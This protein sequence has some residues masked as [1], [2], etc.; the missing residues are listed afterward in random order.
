MKLWR[1]LLVLTI[2]IILCTGVGCTRESR[3]APV[4]SL[5]ID[6]PSLSPQEAI[7]IA[8]QHSVSSPQDVFEQ[9]ASVYARRGGEQGW[10]ATYTGNGK[11]T[12]E[13]RIRNESGD[14]TIYRWTVFEAK[15]TAVF[16]GAYEGN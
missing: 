13:L 2:V 12:V 8:K 4:P 1:V 6:E 9:R 11:W 5:P 14:I 7:A 16:V 15:L 10:S 3:T